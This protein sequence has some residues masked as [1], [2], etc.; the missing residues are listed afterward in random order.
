[1][2]E[3]VIPAEEGFKDLDEALAASAQ[4]GKWALLAPDGRTWFK[5]DLLILLAVISGEMQGIPNRF[6]Q[7]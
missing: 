1:M 6:G 5:A 4:A 3:F 2:N 7:D